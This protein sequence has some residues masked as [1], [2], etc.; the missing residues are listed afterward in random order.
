MLA[1]AS[2]PSHCCAL[3]VLRYILASASLSVTW[4]GP[5]HLLR[6]PASPH[7]PCH[8]LVR[9]PFVDLFHVLLDIHSVCTGNDGVC[10]A[11]PVG[12]LDAVVADPGDRVRPFEQ[13][14]MLQQETFDLAAHRSVH[15]IQTL[16]PAVPQGLQCCWP[17]N[18]AGVFDLCQVDGYVVVPCPCL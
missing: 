6:H 18:M 12:C 15:T 13:R 11:Q 2:D 8:L 1:F 10:A 14:V 5:P 4:C 17:L 9:S 7:R 3:L 16:Q